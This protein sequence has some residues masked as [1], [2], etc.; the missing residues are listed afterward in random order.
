MNEAEALAEILM[1][2]KQLKEW[3]LM[4]YV[5]GGFFI[6]TLSLLSVTIQGWIQWHHM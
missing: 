2:R 6:I 4:A 1:L 3:R 5:A